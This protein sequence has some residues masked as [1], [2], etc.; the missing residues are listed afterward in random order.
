MA[1][2]HFL[3]TLDGRIEEYSETQAAR[4]ATG[5][6]PLPQYAEQRLR[7]VQVAFDE[8]SQAGELHVYTMGA[9]VHFDADGRVSKA[10]A[11]DDEDNVAVSEFEHDACVQ[12]AL[13]GSALL[14]HVL[15]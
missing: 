3:L 11:A 14:G 5:E 4:V 6:A 7:Y 13:R 2:K 8:T 15:N 9:V 12:F 1:T 10:D